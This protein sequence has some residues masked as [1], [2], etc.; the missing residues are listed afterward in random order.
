MTASTRRARYIGRDHDTPVY[1]PPIER[2]DIL[3]IA[4][5]FTVRQK[6]L[7]WAVMAAIGLLFWTAVVC[8]WLS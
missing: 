4:D 2:E 8:W 3:P 7:I 5:E 1:F 6:L